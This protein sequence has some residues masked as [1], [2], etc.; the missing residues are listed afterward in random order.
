Q[1]NP[2]HQGSRNR[3]SKTMTVPAR[4]AFHEAHAALQPIL[5]GIQTVEDLD[6]L[7]HCLN[8]IWYVPC[9]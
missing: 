8:D 5:A 9:T 3:A 1:S 7:V 4:L 6:D 2:L